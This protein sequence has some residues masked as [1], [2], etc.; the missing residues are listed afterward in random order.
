MAERPTLRTAYIAVHY[1]MTNLGLFGLLSTLVVT[2]NAARFSAPQ[3]AALVMIFTITNKIAKIPLAP[4][5][6]RIPAASSVLIG[7]LM[8]A[9]GFVGLRAVTGMTLT[10]VALILAG[11]GV[12]INALASKQLAAIASDDLANRARLFSLINVAVNVASAVAAPAALF[13]AARNKQGYVLLA[14]A[15]VY[16][17]AGIVTFLRYSVGRSFTAGSSARTSVRDYWGIVRLPGMRSFLIINFFGWLLYGQLFNA[18][19]LHVSQTL[20]SAD[21]LGVIAYRRLTDHGLSAMF[22]LFAAGL[23]LVFAGLTQRLRGSSVG[24]RELARTAA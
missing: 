11:T 2:L 22:W 18:L 14:V 10:A 4:W 5:L 7:C 8:A 20:D 21:R 3:I 13:F 23:A 9:A 17:L 16:C 19:A 6:D 24:L 12:S 1:F 15:G